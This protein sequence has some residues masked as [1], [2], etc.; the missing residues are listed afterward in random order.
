MLLIPPKDEA[1]VGMSSESW[2]PVN[3]ARIT[4]VLVGALLVGVLLMVWLLWGQWWSLL[5]A[6]AFMCTETFIASFLLRQLQQEETK[7]IDAMQEAAS[8]VSGDLRQRLEAGSEAL[9]SIG[10][11]SSN[12]L[13]VLGLV[14]S[15]L[16]LMINPGSTELKAFAALVP[17]AFSATGFALLCGTAVSYQTQ[18]VAM[19]FRRQGYLLLDG[20]PVSTDT[21]NAQQLGKLLGV[22]D[23]LMQQQDSQQAAMLLQMRVAEKLEAFTDQA[24]SQQDA[25]QKLSAAAEQFTSAIAQMPVGGDSG[26]DES[27]LMRIATASENACSQLDQIHTDQDK[28]HRAELAAL[29][30]L[31]EAAGTVAGMSESDQV[32]LASNVATLA[33]NIT[34]LAENQLN[35]SIT[36]SKLERAITTQQEALLNKQAHVLKE[37][38]IELATVTMK[39]MAGVMQDQL[40]VRLQG[41]SQQMEIQIK[42]IYATAARSAADHLRAALREV[43]QSSGNTAANLTNVSN[44]LDEVA[45]RL[46][47]LSSAL[48]NNAGRVSNASDVYRDRAAEL[49]AQA[50]ALVS[51]LVSLSGQEGSSLRPIL[52]QFSQTA[53]LLEEAGQQLSHDLKLVKRQEERLRSIRRV[54]IEKFAPYRQEFAAQDSRPRAAQPTPPP[55]MGTLSRAIAPAVP[56]NAAQPAPNHSALEPVHS[57]LVGLAQALISSEQLSGLDEVQARVRQLNPDLH[58][59]SVTIDGQE[60]QAIRASEPLAYVV[61]SRSVWWLLPNTRKVTRFREMLVGGME[62]PPADLISSVERLPVLARAGRSF[63]LQEQGRFV[64]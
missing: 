50:E 19:A 28:A 43:Q 14:A 37:K 49:T 59:Y 60:A 58:A 22:V 62:I 35:A 24:S 30:A 36:M 41:M 40:Q 21:S 63:R 38:T 3:P 10:T 20:L 31:T 6:I 16:F 45:L 8:Q 29:N 17:K 44:Q 34:P 25:V 56:R 7:E 39:S 18:Q 33:R 13:I 61:G 55:R 11:T 5:L 53:T 15:A 52:D 46:G 54:L 12:I 47:N 42:E 23:V 4:G 26:S 32:G 1:A 51:S 48:E 9:H 2:M 57:Q 27:L 64:C